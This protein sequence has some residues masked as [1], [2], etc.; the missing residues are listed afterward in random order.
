MAE[1]SGKPI[2]ILDENSKRIEDEAALDMNVIAIKAIAEAI[3]TILGPKG[4]NKMIVDSMGDITVTSDA[5]KILEEIEIQHPAAKMVVELS[6]TIK[7]SLGDGASTAVILI[8]ELMSKTQEMINNGISPVFVYKGFTLAMNEVKKHLEKIAIKVN[9]EDKNILLQCIK[10]AINSK[11]HGDEKDIIGNM[12]VDSLLNIQEKRG[13]KLSID[14]ENVQ[15]IKKQGGGVNDSK[16]IKG[17]VV[18]KEVVHSM[19]PKVIKNAKIALIDGAL[20]IVKTEFSSEIQ[21][22]NPSQIEAFLLQEEN[23]LKTLVDFIHKA[24]ANVV[25][26]QKGIDETAQHF[27]NIHNIMAIRRVKHSDMEKLS[28]ATGAKIITKIKDIVANDL[29]SSGIVSEQKI[30]KDY[31]I[32]VEDCKELKSVTAVLRGGSEHVVDDIERAFKNG[33]SAGKALIEHPFIVGGGGSVEMELHKVIRD[34]GRKIGGKEQIPIESYADALTCIPRVLIENSGKDS[35]DITTNLKSVVDYNANKYQGY[36]VYSDAIVDVIKS[37]I[38]EP[39]SIKKQV[40]TFSTELAIT[41]TRI[42][43]IIKCNKKGPGGK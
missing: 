10:T 21:I 23:M 18:D 20:E 36:D 16:F 39:L 40:L 8:G 19:M 24:G 14:L 12:I 13:E 43:D 32:Y 2:M 4:L 5:G 38:I 42:D 25:F 37:G 1:L 6:K 34:F 17:I 31:M 35:L 27:L 28:R 26:C 11:M 33:L 29:G 30:G 22:K 7:K 9:P 3:K 41:F 15:I